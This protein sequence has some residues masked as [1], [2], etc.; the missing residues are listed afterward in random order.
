MFKRLLNQEQIHMAG[1][2][3][4]WWSACQ[5]REV[6]GSSPA[7]QETNKHPPSKRKKKKKDA[8]NPIF[9]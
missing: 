9:H 6:L 8:T 1:S 7:P 2:V 3:A 4:Q 5:P